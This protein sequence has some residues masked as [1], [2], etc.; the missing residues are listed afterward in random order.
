MTPPQTPSQSSVSGVMPEVAT[1][2][3]AA[4]EALVGDHRVG[5]AAED[6]H[7]RAVGVGRR[8]RVDQLLLGGGAHPVAGRTAEAKG[9]VVGEEPAG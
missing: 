1:S 7:G 4:V 5:P 6:E 2:T 9:G 8:D 3:T